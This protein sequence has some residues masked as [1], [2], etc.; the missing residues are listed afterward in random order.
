MP[1]NGPTPH[2]KRA[3]LQAMATATLAACVLLPAG[4]SASAA[5]RSR[6]PAAVTAV[7][8]PAGAV[9]PAQTPYDRIAVQTL[10]AIVSGDFTAATAHFD[11]TVRKLLTPEALAAAWK[12]YQATF[13]RYQ[14]HGD[15][16]DVARG[17]STVVN[18]PL[19]MESQAGE[20]RLNFHKN[21]SIAGLWF[22]KTGVPIP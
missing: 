15:P 8:R 20:F 14:S 13:G 18:V 1:D 19:R 6:A 4:G 3:L 5:V 22:L 12:T 10:D 11:P 9:S 17:D 21:G 16:E 2:S 7:T